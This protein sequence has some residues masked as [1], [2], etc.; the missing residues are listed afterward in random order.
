ML[1]RG[2]EQM[3]KS[4]KDVK[5]VLIQYKKAMNMVRDLSDQIVEQDMRMKTIKSPN[6]SG[7]PRG[8]A[9]YTLDDAIADKE[10]LISRKLRFEKIA[11]QQKEIVQSYID[12]V[13]SVRHNRFLTL[14]YIKLYNVSEIALKE[15][16]TER[17]VW[18]IYNEALAMVDLSLDL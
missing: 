18:R 11:K 12:T 13:M 15:G 14:Y 9:P 8:G 1:W 16:Y 7:M 4:N 3:S 10:G 2:A 17:H 6:Y 5:K